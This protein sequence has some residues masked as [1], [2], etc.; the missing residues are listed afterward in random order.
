MSAPSFNFQA[1]RAE[2]E[3][4]HGRKGSSGERKWKVGHERWIDGEV[5]MENNRKGRREKLK[6]AHTKWFVPLPSS[7]C[8]S[9]RSKRRCV[10]ERVERQLIIQGGGFAVCRVYFIYLFFLQSFLFQQQADV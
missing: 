1:A 7:V 3:N 9:F 4:F 6:C 5:E 10:S 8:G 2:I